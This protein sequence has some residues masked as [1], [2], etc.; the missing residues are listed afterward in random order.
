MKISIGSDHGGYELK[1]KIIKFLNAKKHRVIDRGT[2][3]A[4]SVDY[5]DYARKVARDVAARRAKFGILICGSGIGMAMAANKVKGIRAAS[6]E[7][8]YNAKMS[9]AHNDANVITI[10]AR[11][12]RPADARKWVDIFL[13]TK[14][15]GGRHVR[16]VQK[17]EKL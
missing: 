14:F 15:E 8:A 6:V 7:S 4:E 17:I 13:K 2:N 16:R 11:I 9:R 1:E 3:S 10:G 12:T 5:P